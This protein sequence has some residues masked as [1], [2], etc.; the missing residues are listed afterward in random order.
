V[1]L[2]RATG[3]YD[4]TEPRMGFVALM[5]DLH[6]GRDSGRVWSWVID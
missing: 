1:F 6:K 3:A 5:N 4:L 2:D